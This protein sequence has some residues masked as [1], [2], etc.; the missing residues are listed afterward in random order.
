MKQALHMVFSAMI[1]VALIFSAAS[2]PPQHA[3]AAS[4]YTPFGGKVISYKPKSDAA[5]VKTTCGTL[6][7]TIRVPIKAAADAVLT[8][9]G[10][11]VALIPVAHAIIDKIDACSVE[12]IKIGSPK[13]ATIGILKFGR[14]LVEPRLFWFAG[15]RVKVLDASVSDLLGLPVLDPII[16]DR[17]NHTRLGAWVL[18]DSL[19]LLKACELASGDSRKP[20]I[21]SHTFLKPV[22]SV[23]REGK[24]KIMGDARQETLDAGG[25][26]NEAEEAAKKAGLDYVM[27]CPFLNLA[28][29]IGSN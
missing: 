7:K 5:C 9:T 15:P 6:N 28:H 14:I 11:G 13:P 20:P 3:E 16:H 10:V 2:F 21:C 19:D 12:E 29:R 17:G 4:L 18:G 25:T 8:A 22:L 23:L 24:K 27:N 1:L 26:P